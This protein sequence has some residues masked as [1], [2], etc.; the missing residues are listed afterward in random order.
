MTL[1]NTRQVAEQLGVSVVRVRQLIREGKIEAHNLGR[2]YAISKDALADVVVYGKPGRPRL[3]D[4]ER[5]V[6]AEKRT[7]EKGVQA[8]GFKRPATT[9]KPVRKA[10]AKKA[11]SKKAARKRGAAE[12]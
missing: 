7:A 6:R 5:A 12:K 2:D 9:A 1:L 4:E 10:R 8:L 11:G 3:T